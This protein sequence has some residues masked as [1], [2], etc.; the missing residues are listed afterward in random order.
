MLPPLSRNFLATHGKSTSAASGTSFGHMP[1]R[2]AAGP[3]LPGK[4]NLDDE[5][6]ATHECLVD[7]L[8]QIGGEYRDA[9]VLLH[10]LQQ[11]GD[12]DVGVAVVRI[13]HVGAL[14][15]QRVGLV[16][17]QNGVRA[18]AAREYLIAGS[19]RSR[20]CTC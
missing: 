18:S 3:R 17:E 19:S 2:S 11:V 10:L 7:V 12:L 1:A 20:L 14:A 13:L 8:A 6:H 15:E 5:A 4:G 16:E 9:L